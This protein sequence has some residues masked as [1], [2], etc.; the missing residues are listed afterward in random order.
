MTENEEVESQKEEPKKELTESDK[1]V[2][3]IREQLNIGDLISKGYLTIELE[4][5]PDILKGKFRSLSG[6]QVKAINKDV[7]RFASPKYTINKSGERK[8]TDDAP[9]QQEILDYIK[10]RN[11]SESLLEVNEVSL[12]RSQAERDKKLD[13]L[14]SSIVTA[15]YYKMRQFFAAVSLLFPDEDQEKQLDSLKN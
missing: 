5:K 14:D 9:T 8:L 4:V 15:L 3:E 10:Y 12:G 6:E 13:K 7:A 1:K 2:L 11:L